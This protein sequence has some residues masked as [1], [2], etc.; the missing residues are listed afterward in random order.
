M[1]MLEAIKILIFTLK[2]WTR[3]GRDSFFLTRLLCQ[4]VLNVHDMTE[5]D[6]S[7]T[8]SVGTHRDRSVLPQPFTK[9]SLLFRDVT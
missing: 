2:G 6:T 3:A 7:A 5:I 9:G 1:S 4:F 8:G